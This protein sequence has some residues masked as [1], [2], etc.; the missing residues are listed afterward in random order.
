MSASQEVQSE[1]A[2]ALQRKAAGE[3]SQ[4]SQIHT[5]LYTVNLWGAVK[6]EGGEERKIT[7]G[8]YEVGR[9]STGPQLQ[10]LR[11]LYDSFNVNFKLDSVTEYILLKPGTSVKSKASLERTSRRITEVVSCEVHKS[12]SAQ[13]IAVQNR[14]LKVLN[15]QKGPKS[16]HPSHDNYFTSE[17]L[18]TLI[19]QYSLKLIN[20]HCVLITHTV[21]AMEYLLILG[22]MVYC[23]WKSDELDHM[24]C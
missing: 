17:K 1:A 7:V 13:R 9:E 20:G 10:S 12:S 15:D 2:S 6:C 16:G 14:I 3:R 23:D 5:R 22:L 18:H 8:N 21:G 4:A 11:L 19:P 24:D